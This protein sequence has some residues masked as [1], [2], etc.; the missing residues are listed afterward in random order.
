MVKTPNN[1]CDGK[2]KIY[3]TNSVSGYFEAQVIK[4]LNKRYKLIVTC[5]DHEVT[6]NLNNVGTYETFPFQFGNGEYAIRLY[7][8][9]RGKKYLRVGRIVIPVKIV[10]EFQPFLTKNQYVTWLNYSIDIEAKQITAGLNTNEDIIAAVKSYISHNY[11]YDAVKAIKIAKKT[12][13]LPDIDGIFMK[14]K[15][16]C[17]DIAG[18]GCTFM[19]LNSIPCKFV[20]GKADKTS[21]AWCEIW[22]Y[23]DEKWEIW[24][25]MS[26]ILSKNGKK[27]KIKYVVERWY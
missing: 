6:Y 9:V 5:G 14:K 18:L 15:G 3:R 1:Y 20:V 25:P 11:V 24:D 27:R 7:E 26:D 4:P 16:V 19:R 21:H 8:N 17:Q 13:I 22:N 23:T 12:G 2:L 10:D